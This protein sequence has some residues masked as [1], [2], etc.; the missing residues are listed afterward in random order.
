MRREKLSDEQ[1][2]VPEID[3]IILLDR[4]VDL[5][6][7]F[8]TQLTYEG[9]IDEVFGITDE[10]NIAEAL[11]NFTRDPVFRDILECEQS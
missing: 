11:L 1:L 8:C 7:P 3:T 5:L 9:L 10:S 2:V 4:E 6:T